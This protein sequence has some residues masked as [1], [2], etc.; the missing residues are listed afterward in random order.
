MH[1]DGAANCRNP[2][3]NIGTTSSRMAFYGN[4]IMLRGKLRAHD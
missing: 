4:A 3:C 2:G 1:R